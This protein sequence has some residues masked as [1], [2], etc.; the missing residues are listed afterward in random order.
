MWVKICANTCVEDALAAIEFGADA[1]GF[2]FAPSPRQVSAVQVREITRRLPVSIETVGVF[3]GA[4]SDAIAKAVTEAGL[5][6]VQLHGGVNLD[7]V[8]QL[9][10]RLGPE[11]A[12]IHTAH[13]AVDVQSTPA[14]GVASAA[15]LLAEQGGDPRLLVD[16]IVG[17]SSGGL[18]ISFNWESARSAFSL[19]EQAGVRV[20]VAGG[21]RPDNVIEAVRTLRPWGVDVASG[22]EREPGRKDYAR[23]KA[24]IDNSKSPLPE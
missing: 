16:A 8:D 24:F 20:I 3:A 10:R 21:L 5:R 18:G 12:M 4:D 6:T 23:L 9:R 14:D 2:V 19:A 15:R 7:L 17:E 1:V 13:R 11:I 22:V